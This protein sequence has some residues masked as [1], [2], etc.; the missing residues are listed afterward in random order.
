MT[1][2]TGYV[3]LHRRN[4]QQWFSPT[5]NLRGRY[6]YPYIVKELESWVER[7]KTAATQSNDTYAVTNNHN[8]GKAVV[9]ALEISSILTG[10]PVNAPESLL[11]WYPDRREFTG[12]SP[13]INVEH[14]RAQ[15]LNRW[16]RQ[17]SRFDDE[18]G[19]LCAESGV[20]RRF[21]CPE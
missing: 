12:E 9:D 8:R 2:A 17:W 16:S 15:R 3:R 14:R 6:D 18:D 1:A 7:I 20:A 21:E 13:R 19:K 11:E 10:E 4:C 5:A